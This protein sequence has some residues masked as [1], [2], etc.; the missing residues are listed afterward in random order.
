MRAW[1]M[2]PIVLMACGG[3]TTGSS[4]A[5]TPDSGIDAV[6]DSLADSAPDSTADS[7]AIDASAID[8]SAV[9]C[10]VGAPCEHHNEFG[11]C[12]AI[13]KECPAGGGVGLCNAG[14]PKPEIC[15]GQDD[16]CN[17]MTDDNLC[18][19]GDPATTGY[20]DGTVCAQK[21]VC[22]D[23]AIGNAC[24]AAGSLDPGDKCKVCNPMQSKTS[25]V[26]QAGLTCDDGDACTTGDVCSKGKCAGTAMDCSSQAGACGAAS[27]V[28]GKCVVSG[29]AG[30]C[31]PGDVGTCADPCETRICGT[32]CQ[33]QA[34]G[35]KAGASCAYKS[36]LNHQCCAPGS[37]Q[38]CSKTT[39]NWYPCQADAASGC[40]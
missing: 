14:T 31:K 36:G 6:A 32:D 39:C 12:K 3:N 35:L 4:F 20:C 38:F 26:A 2:I 29:G 18:E 33:W 11:T 27:C 15:N 40:P 8:T 24:I 10:K 25:Y 21:P 7:S 28:G 9:T 16:D 30:V 34:C 13:I 17:G 22:P 1:L 5:A 23:C 37:W 19:D